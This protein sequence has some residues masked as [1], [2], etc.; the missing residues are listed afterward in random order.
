M[1]SRS[2][3]GRED[4]AEM[5]SVLRAVSTV[6]ALGWFANALLH[7]LLLV[8]M[9]LGALVLGGGHEVMP[10]AMRPVNA[11]LVV[12]WGVC[13][14][15]YLA[16]GGVVAH[17]ASRGRLRSGLVVMTVFL[18]LASVFNLFITSSPAERYVTGALSALML[19]LSLVLLL[20]SSQQARSVSWLRCEA[21]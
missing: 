19:L 14:W 11:L 16:Y 12:L 15:A 20:G 2:D 10:V 18:L 21:S 13:G 1:R 8:G 4:V 6:C 3:A 5:C 7:L 17:R 9:P